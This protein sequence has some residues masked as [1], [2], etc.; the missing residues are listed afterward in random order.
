MIIKSDRYTDQGKIGE[1]GKD[2][3]RVSELTKDDYKWGRIAYLHHDA[4][5]DYYI[6]YESVAEAM[7]YEMDK[8]A[9]EY[10]RWMK[11]GKRS[12]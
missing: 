7:K 6:V 12:K 9:A 3:Y 5:G 4:A 11:H 2:M 8:A 10:E 1:R